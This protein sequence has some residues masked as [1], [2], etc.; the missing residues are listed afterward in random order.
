MEERTMRILQRKENAAEKVEPKRRPVHSIRLKNIRASVWQNESEDGPW[1][2]VTLSR[3]YRS[4]TGEWQSSDGFSRDDLLLV[5]KVA[6]LAHT[7]CLE[8]PP[9]KEE[10]SEE[11]GKASPRQ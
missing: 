9:G 6:D 1:F 5:A 8:H 7:F 2:N 11:E 4:H 10:E 3:L